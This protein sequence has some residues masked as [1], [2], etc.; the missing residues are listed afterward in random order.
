MGNI[1]LEKFQKI[2]RAFEK[3][4]YLESGNPFSF[5][6]EKCLN[7][8]LRN[9]IGHCAYK[10]SNAN[11]VISYDKHRKE[12][13]LLNVLLDSYEMMMY[14]VKTFD[15]VTLLHEAYYKFK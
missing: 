10:V 4:K 8:K 6:L 5:G 13:S 15:V 1:D 7:N 14:L 3:I 2:D 11:Q 12:I 9:S